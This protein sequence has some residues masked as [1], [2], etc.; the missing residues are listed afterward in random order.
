M[1]LQQLRVFL[2]IVEFGSFRR[3]ARELGVSQAGLTNSLQ[4]LEVGLGVTLLL[5]SAMGV[6]LTPEGKSLLARA[7]LID[8]EARRAVEEAH[9]ARGDIGGTLH[10]GLGPTP[11][12]ALLQLV[13]PDFHR[14][15]PAV[16]LKLS[17][18]L[19]EQLLPPLQQGLIELALTAVPDE[20]PGPGFKS[21]TLFRSDL[22]VVGR[23]DHPRAAA[24]SLRDLADCEWILLGSPGGPGGTVTR[25]HAEQGLPPPRVAATCESFTQLAA[26]ISG[27]DWLALLP[28]VVT[29]RG[30]LGTEVVAIKLKER[31][32][33]FENH[34][35]YRADP[36]LTPAAAAFASM[37]ESGARI[38]GRGRSLTA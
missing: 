32:Q 31:S 7:Q 18:G 14:R 38:V 30:L 17:S 25:F 9:Y 4:A 23:R 13:V 15:F 12:A 35:V 37:C 34:L 19:Y 1:T 24:H 3:A 22:V 2:A 36:P 16:K 6:A 11:T 26:L 21:K 8:R 10:V 29:K 5:R 33:G 20:G 27:T 28:A